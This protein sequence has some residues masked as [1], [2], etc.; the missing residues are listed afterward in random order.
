MRK[1][2]ASVISSGASRRW[3]RL[4][5]APAR[6][7]AS[8][9][10]EIWVGTWAAAPQ[11]TEPANL[12]PAPGFADTTLRQIVHVSIGGRTL[13]VRFSNAFGRTRR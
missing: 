3:R 1:R 5:P 9:S 4:A 13:R 10:G 8:G 12:P 11:L 7:R 2:P 6:Q